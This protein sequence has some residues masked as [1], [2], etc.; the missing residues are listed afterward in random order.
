MFFFSS[1]YYFM[2]GFTRESTKDGEMADV[3]PPANTSE[4]I[5]LLFLTEDFTCVSLVICLLSSS[6]CDSHCKSP[7]G[8]MK[9]TMKKY[10][11]KDFGKQLFFQKRLLSFHFTSLDIFLFQVYSISL[12]ICAPPLSY[13]GQLIQR[14]KVCVIASK[15]VNSAGFS[16]WTLSN[17][18]AASR[19]QRGQLD[20]VQSRDFT[21]LNTNIVN[22]IKDSQK[23]KNVVVGFKWHNRFLKIWS[24]PVFFVFL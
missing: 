8:K 16:R 20:P 24:M 23:F 11:K 13:R 2:S 18:L 10:C 5:I 12:S 15:R 22:I 17:C 4:N 19:G 3:S 1:D 14:L 21:S 7:K 6:D 9:V